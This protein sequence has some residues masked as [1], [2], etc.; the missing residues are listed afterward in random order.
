MRHETGFAMTTILATLLFGHSAVAGS[1][2]FTP[3]TGFD[4]KRYLGTW[5]EIA[6]LPTPFEKGL[7]NVTATYSLRND[8][9][10]KVLNAGYKGGKSG[11]R[12]SATGKAKFAA[13]PDL[14]HLRVSFFGPFYADYI[15]VELDG[16]GYRYAMV[17]SSYDYL[18]ILCRDPKLPRDVL[19]RLIARADELGFDTGKL[20]M[21]P[22]D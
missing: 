3:V 18:W 22:Q 10:V 5:Y 14:G 16:E 8:G 20:Y 9:K 17:A 4:L 11:K 15:I 21:V 19:D 1:P 12:S 13:A 2:R 7:V 6:R